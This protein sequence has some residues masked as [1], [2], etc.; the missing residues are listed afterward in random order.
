M[1]FGAFVCG[2][3]LFDDPLDGIRT[4]DDI[5]E[6][7][8][9]GDLPWTAMQNYMAGMDAQGQLLRGVM[10]WVMDAPGGT[11]TTLDALPGVRRLGNTLTETQRTSIETWLAARGVM[12]SITNAL[13]M[14]DQVCRIALAL[15]PAFKVPPPW[16]TA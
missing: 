7:M 4:A 1:A 2:L 6:R 12:T 8:A 16:F 5:G 13:T 10:L 11:L 9:E 15:N 3:W 14:R